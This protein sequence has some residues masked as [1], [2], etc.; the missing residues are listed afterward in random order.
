[1]GAANPESFHR[2]RPGGIHG[3]I[4][5]LHSRGSGLVWAKVAAFNDPGTLIAL[6]RGSGGWESHLGAIAYYTGAAGGG[7]TIALG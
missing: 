6:L 2:S 5:R 1:M 4:R 3:T 7:M